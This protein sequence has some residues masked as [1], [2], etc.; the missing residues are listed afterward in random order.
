MTGNKQI[1]QLFK[2]LS[3]FWILTAC[4]TGGYDSEALDYSLTDIQKV[5][6]ESMPAEV[7]YVSQN[8]RE[9]FT[10][11][12]KLN[13]ENAKPITI[14]VKSVILGDRRPYKI[15]VEAHVVKAKTN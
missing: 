14:I 10:K 6:S 13:V 4:A 1:K 9:Y 11:P 8:G 15:S 2:I 7:G 12:F 5:L 3:L